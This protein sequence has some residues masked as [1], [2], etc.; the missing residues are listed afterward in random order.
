ME[1]EFKLPVTSKIDLSDPA[2]ATIWELEQQ[3]TSNT[4]WTDK[5]KG[6]WSEMWR[7]TSSVLEVN[8]V[9]SWTNGNS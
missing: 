5:E 4:K 8:V 7:L 3:L 1:I 9:Q 2:I 6:M